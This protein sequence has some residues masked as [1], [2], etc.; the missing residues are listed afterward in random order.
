MADIPEGVL[1]G[2]ATGNFVDFLTSVEG[3][4]TPDVVGLNGYVVISPS[5]D[6]LNVDGD[7]MT[8]FGRVMV[9]PVFNG[10]IYAP[11]TSEADVVA[12]LK[13]DGVS[14]VA[15]T[16]T[17]TNPTSF[18]YT[19][20]FHLNGVEHQPTATPFEILSGE[21]IDLGAIVPISPPPVGTT[22]VVTREDY[23]AAV[24]AAEEAE[25]A[26]AGLS[27]PVVLSQAEYDALPTPDPDTYYYIA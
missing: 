2:T 1:W 13:D 26:A 7:V 25:T 6:R 11:G 24:A 18:H 20:E 21:V 3:D 22:Y 15:T 17:I 27:A 4:E 10:L 5:I 16:Q 8:A 12:G 9:C 14:L 23:L 19:V